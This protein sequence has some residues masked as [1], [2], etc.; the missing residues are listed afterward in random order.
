MVVGVENVGGKVYVKATGLFNKIASTTN[1]R[2]HGI[3]Y[4][5]AHDFQ[6]PQLCIQK[7][8]VWI[9]Q[10][11][12]YGLDNFNIQLFQSADALQKLLSRIDFGLG[13]A[14]WIEVYSHIFRI[15]Y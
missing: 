11:L 13:D 5:S 9:D 7:A 3:N 15:S 10:P 1:N 8:K 2:I 6:P 14:S 4:W 12:R